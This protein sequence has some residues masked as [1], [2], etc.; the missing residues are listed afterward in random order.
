MSP[1]SVGY[2]PHLYS[3]STDVVDRPRDEIEQVHFQRIDDDAPKV[4]NKIIKNEELD[5]A[6]VEVWTEFILN[7]KVRTP[8]NV[9]YMKDFWRKTVNDLKLR[10]EN[11]RD[12]EE[13][14]YQ[15]VKTKSDKTPDDIAVSQIP[16]V[17]SNERAKKDLKA[18]VWRSVAFDNT[19]RPLV[20][21][22]RPLIVTSGFHK[23]DCIVALPITPRLAFVAF[24]SGSNSER[25]LMT[26]GASELVK[27]INN[28]VVRAADKFV[29]TKFEGDIS[30]RFL[31]QR[32]K[33]LKF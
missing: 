14:F 20:S 16:A 19:K 22:D 10:E 17:G 8:E 9:E 21:S 12:E 18:F 24:R 7:L 25:H 27:A 6:D 32:M 26:L 15:W 2:K 31:D 29:F 1:A 4:L 28:A 23:A 3:Y 30:E 33:P 11:L 13:S 5:A